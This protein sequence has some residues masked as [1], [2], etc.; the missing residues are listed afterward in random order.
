MESDAGGMKNQISA[1]LISVVLACAITPGRAEDNSVQSPVLPVVELFT[2]QSC[3]SC[4]PAEAYFRSL[5]SRDDIVVMEW[6]VDYW[7]GLKVRGAGAWRDPF[8]D[9]AFTERQRRYNAVLRKTNNVY[10]PQAVIAG[11]F[12]TV[13]SRTGQ[14]DNYI[15]RIDRQD[16]SFISFEKTDGVASVILPDGLLSEGDEMRLVTFH[17]RAE[18][19][20][21]G[22]EN[23]GLQLAE[24]HVV[25][26]D[27][28]L[29]AEAD[30]IVRFEPPENGSGCAIVIVD[31][32][33]LAR[34]AAYCPS[35][36][37]HRAPA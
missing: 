21:A 22:G 26:T 33:G 4:P 35:F 17:K 14:I 29:E 30:G 19:K 37:S 24:A 16:A 5:A 18:T 12:E 15:N 6:H 31:K 1:A 8:S 36:T 28:G 20:V 2:S 10:T 32:A 3:S 9:A 11:Q 25:H 34:R 23:S 27:E 13:G 7:N